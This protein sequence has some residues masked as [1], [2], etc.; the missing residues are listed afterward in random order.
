MEASVEKVLNL[1]IMGTFFT[2]YIIITTRV[3]SLLYPGLC[4]CVRVYVC[5][6]VGGVIQGGTALFHVQVNPPTRQE[7]SSDTTPSTPST[8][9]TPPLK[10]MR[11]VFPSLY[12]SLSSSSPC[13]P[14][15]LFSLHLLHYF[16]FLTW[17]FPFSLLPVSLLPPSAPLFPSLRLVSSF[18]ILPHLSFLTTLECCHLAVRHHQHYYRVFS[19]CTS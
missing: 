3:F 5:G 9:S 6:C 18:C 16:L 8:P 10:G 19:A 12:I 17:F 13:L 14:S 15:F 7:G 4:L 11:A 1:N 2:E